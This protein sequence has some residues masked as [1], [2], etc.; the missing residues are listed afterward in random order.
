[1]TL[2]QA[3]ERA[4][5]LTSTNRENQAAYPP[6]R[7]PPPFD[8]DREVTALARLWN[9]SDRESRLEFLEMVQDIN[10]ELIEP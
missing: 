7:K 9:R 3:Q 4:A 1:M 2:E 5:Y 10:G 8:K 6:I